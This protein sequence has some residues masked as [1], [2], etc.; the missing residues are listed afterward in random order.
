L[1]G[2]LLLSRFALNREEHA[3]LRGAID[4]RRDEGQG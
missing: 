3:A 4:A 1:L 2:A